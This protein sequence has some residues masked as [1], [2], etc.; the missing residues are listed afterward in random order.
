MD[1]IRQLE[2]KKLDPPTE[3]NQKMIRKII[4]IYVKTKL[5]ISNEEEVDLLKS[6]EILVNNA[7]N[8]FLNNDAA[9]AL[10]EELTNPKNKVTEIE[11]NQLYKKLHS[12]L[13][14][15]Q[16]YKID[17]DADTFD[18]IGSF[19]E[20]YSSQKEEFV[21]Y[22]L[23]CFGQSVLF[24]CFAERLQLTK[25]LKFQYTRTHINL[26]CRIPS[27]E[28]YQK[29]FKHVPQFA[30]QTTR[31]RI[32]SCNRY[33]LCS[34]MTVSSKSIV[35]TYA[36]YLDYNNPQS[37]E[38]KLESSPNKTYKQIK[39][40][41]KYCNDIF[42]DRKP[43]LP[44]E[45]EFFSLLNQ[46]LQY[47]FHNYLL[48]EYERWLYLG[49]KFIRSVLRIYLT[50]KRF[51]EQQQQQ[52]QQQQ[53]PPY[54]YVRLIELAFK[55]EFPKFLEYGLIITL[56]HTFLIK[57]N[58]KDKIKFGYTSQQQY[59]GEK[60]DHYRLLAFL[61]I[62]Y[63]NLYY[64]SRNPKEISINPLKAA[65]RYWMKK[66]FVKII[67]GTRNGLLTIHKKKLLRNTFFQSLNDDHLFSKEDL[68]VGKKIL[69]QCIDAFGNYFANEEMIDK[70][71][72]DDHNEKKRQ[73]QQELERKKRRQQAERKRKQQ[74]LEL[75]RKRKQQ[76][77]QQLEL[78]RKRKQQH[79]LEKKRKQQ[80]QQQLEL[81]RK[82]KQQQQL[83]LE[84]KR[85]RQQ[86]QQELE[87]KRKQLQKMMIRK[88]KRNEQ[89]QQQKQI[90]AQA[91]AH[92]KKKRTTDH[93][94]NDTMMTIDFNI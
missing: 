25:Y 26:R 83:E 23:N 58:P 81:E 43:M 47:S 52:Q 88:R 32:Y 53:Y 20:P 38:T 28:K 10:I 80:Q 17:Y 73:Q 74:Q 87:R 54:K 35:S 91:Q 31:N 42:F 57:E 76:Q 59:N 6:F 40:F 44:T 60:I 24:Y 18:M 75:E 64:D 27:N 4:H 93:Y 65:I 61:C 5:S 11:M 55:Q 9:Q 37:L 7:W 12:V 48:R 2:A 22:Y 21:I 13:F 86:L 30:F 1:F 41:E 70:D 15:R 71:D 68:Q 56:F 29:E 36:E 92:K 79:E 51:Q 89:Q 16:N 69:E 85:K 45:N 34:L 3:R 14:N 63:G 82:R 39:E 66:S 72:D 94:D 62:L 77:Q 50:F 49:S 78:E 33:P 46:C 90:Q 84:R 67:D 19:L 8:S